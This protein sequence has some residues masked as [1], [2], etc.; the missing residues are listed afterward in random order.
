MSI[1]IVKTDAEL[2]AAALAE[3]EEFYRHTERMP[4]DLTWEDVA[5]HLG[6]SR[7]TAR[8]V[9]SRLVAQGKFQ[10]LRM[11]VD[12]HTRTVYRKVES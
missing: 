2:K 6:K 8:Q 7:E 5:A 9:M 4:G 10:K 1:T 3:I 12:G 11:P